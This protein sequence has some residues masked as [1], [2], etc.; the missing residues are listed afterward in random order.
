[1]PRISVRIK[2]DQFDEL[3]FIKNQNKKTLSEMIRIS[4]QKSIDNYKRTQHERNSNIST[5]EKG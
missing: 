2:Q 1:M 3:L 4:L 5:T